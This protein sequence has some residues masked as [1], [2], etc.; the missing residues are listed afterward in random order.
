MI[1][2]N[3]LTS[4][5]GLGGGGLDNNKDRDQLW[6]RYFPRSQEIN[7]QIWGGNS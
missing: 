7:I 6:E 5:D 4:N 2:D 1:S 3:N